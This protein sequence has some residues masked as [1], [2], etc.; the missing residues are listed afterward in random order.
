LSIATVLA[1]I[2]TCPASAKELIVC[3]FPASR[4]VIVSLDDSKI[5]GRMLNCIE[6]TFTHGIKRCARNN[7]FGIFTSGGSEE[8]L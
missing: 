4:D 3:H 5:A 1:L 8:S 6:G 2:V 7:A